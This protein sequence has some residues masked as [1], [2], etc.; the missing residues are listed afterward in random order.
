MHAGFVDGID[1]GVGIRVGGEQGALGERVHLHGFG[2]E[3]HAVHLGHTLIRQQ[4]RDGIVARFQFPQSGK[5]GASGIRAHDAVA[6]RVTAA[7]IALNGPEDLRVVIN[8]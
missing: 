4:Q 5:P 8:C 6:I 7:Q 1:G 3:I 2:E